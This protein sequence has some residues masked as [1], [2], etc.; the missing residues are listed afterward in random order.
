MTEHPQ[1][2]PPQQPPEPSYG[3]Q[4]GQPM[5]PYGQQAPQYGHQPPQYYG[6]PPTPPMGGPGSAYGP[7]GQP[8]VSP[9]DARM[10]SMFAH[11]GGLFLSFLVPL[12][13]YLVYKDRDP[14]IR[15]HAAQAMNFIIIIYI[16]YFVS[17]LL[18]IVIVGF[19]TFATAVVCHL[20]FVILAAV[21][22]N[23]GRQYFYPLTP[24]MI[25]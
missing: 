14:F 2:R 5:P 4:P 8:P 12:V 3:Q 17:A 24:R 20:V 21:A 11:L 18:F 7:Q 23:E 15:H 10:W 9:S 22:A 6:A 13:I 16:I 19:F 1:D 25:S